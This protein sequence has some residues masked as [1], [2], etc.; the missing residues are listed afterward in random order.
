MYIYVHVCNFCP[1][2]NLFGHAPV[3][4]LNTP[5]QD[6]LRFDSWLGSTVQSMIAQYKSHGG[7]RY[8]TF[9]STWN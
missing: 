2:K 1:Y 3:Q 7:T 6:E 4:R 8:G 5:P 9:L